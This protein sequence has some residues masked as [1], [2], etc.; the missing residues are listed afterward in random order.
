[1]TDKLYGLPLYQDCNILMYRADIYAELGLDVPDTVEDLMANA[2]AISEWG[3]DKGV[4]GI[5]LRGQRG[6]GVNEWTWPTFLWAYGGSYYKD[7][8]KDMHPAWT[9]RKRW[10]LWNI[11]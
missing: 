3:K 4:Y 6:M 10:P 7:F 9:A 11:T 8:P 5:A 2:K 1:M